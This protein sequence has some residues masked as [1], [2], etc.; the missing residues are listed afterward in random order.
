MEVGPP[1]VA[2][3]RAMVRIR[4]H[5]T[6]RTLG[7]FVT[8][9][10]DRSVD[11]T[12]TVVVDAVEEEP[13]EPG[14]EVTVGLVAERPAV[15]PSRAGRL[16]A[17]GVEAGYVRR[18]VSRA[19]SRR[20]CLELTDA[21]RALALLTHRVRQQF[22]GEI[23]QDR[24]PQERKDF[25]R[26]LGKFAGLPPGSQYLDGVQD[27]GSRGA[28]SAGSSPPWRQTPS[29]GAATS[30]MYETPVD[31]AS[32]RRRQTSR[33][34]IRPSGRTSGVLTH[35][36]AITVPPRSAWQYAGRSVPSASQLPTSRRGAPCHHGT[37]PTRGAPTG[38][39]APPAR[40]GV[41]RVEPLL[42]GRRP[43]VSLGAVRPDRAIGTARAPGAPVHR[44]VGAVL[45]QPVENL[46]TTQ[47]LARRGDVLG[48]RTAVT[49]AQ[50]GARCV[51]QHGGRCV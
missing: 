31:L 7:R 18:V 28:R 9:R 25:A 40:P 34:R 23:M 14:Q 6:K 44:D 16:V 13:E 29:G 22:L 21:G 8:S 30:P 12:H 10:L 48:I 11:L 3:E 50:H 41:V 4:R 47:P 24:S 15:D 26:L 36:P 51:R 33:G 35:S 43:T 46:R 42:H 39:S 17:A 5:Q 1:L 2:V 37:R 32:S 38:G 49:D 45:D 27:D 20:A 19:D